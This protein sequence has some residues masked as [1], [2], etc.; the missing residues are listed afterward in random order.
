[1][2]PPYAVAMH[3]DRGEKPQELRGDRAGVLRAGGAPRGAGPAPDRPPR[4]VHPPDD[5]SGDGHAPHRPRAG[6]EGVDCGLH[7]HH[8]PAYLDTLYEGDR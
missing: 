1:M 6:G 5:P 4:S 7:L 3:V 2:R 8:A